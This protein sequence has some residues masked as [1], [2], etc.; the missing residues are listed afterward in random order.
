[1]ELYNLAKLAALLGIEKQWMNEKFLIAPRGEQ[2]ALP[3]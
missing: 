2:I 3:H 1:L